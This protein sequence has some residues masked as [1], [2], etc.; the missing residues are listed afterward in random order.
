MAQWTIDPDHSVAAFVV[1]HMMVCDVHGQFNRVSGT[2][3]FDPAE[4]ENTALDVT[5][6]VTGVYTGIQKRDE[7]LRSP[8]FFDAAAYPVMTFT[9]NRVEARGDNRYTVA[10]NLTIRGITRQVV[11]EA[12][13]RGPV[14]SPFGDETT[15]GFTATTTIDR[16]EFGVSWNELMEGWGVVVGNRVAITLNVEADMVE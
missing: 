13:T 4:P 7:H 10:G 15:I 6:E 8:D 11:L 3:R 1:R 12:E 9:S 16:T 5:I 2:I 14:K